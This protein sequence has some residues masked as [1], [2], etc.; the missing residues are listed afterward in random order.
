[1]SYSFTVRGALKS[2]AMELVAVELGKVVSQQ[3][4]HNKDH[5]AAIDTA[6]LF[7]DMLEVDESKDVQVTVSGSISE[8]TTG[9]RYVS[10]NVTAT[11][12]DKV[13]PDDN[14]VPQ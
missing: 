9:V 6:K 14:K 11:L 10:C 8:A 4:V 7:S 3:S 1:M 13:K 2:A 5:D 12:V